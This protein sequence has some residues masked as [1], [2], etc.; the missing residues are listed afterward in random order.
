DIDL[1]K[2]LSDDSDANWRDSSGLRTI[3]LRQLDEQLYQTIAA[4]G[5]PDAELMNLGG[6]SRISLVH[7]DVVEQDIRLIGPAGQPSVGFRLEDLSLLASLV[8]DQTRPLGCSI[9]PQEAGLRRAHNMLANPQTVKLLARNP[10]RV[11]DQLADAVGPHEVSVFGMPASSPAALALVDADEHMKKVGF[12]KAQVRPAVRTYFQCLDDGAVPAQS[13]VRWWFAYRDASIGVN[14]AGDT[15]KLPNGC[16]AVMSEKQWMTAVG[17]KA[18]QN[19]DPAADKFAKEFTEKLPE[20]RKS[21]PAYARL[22]AIFETALALQLSVDAAGEPSLES[23]FPTL[24]GL[25][26]LSQADQPV[27]KSVDGLTTSHKLP[28]GTTIAVVSG[29][30]QITPSAAAELVKESKFMA[31][32]ALPREPEVKPAGQAKWWW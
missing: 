29:G 12:G 21:T 11:V 8:R 20:L 10:K 32:S 6:L 9:D 13:M 3:S 28:S 2:V 19:R 27:P 1:S 18:S 22:C 24:C 30:V 16:V 5:R 26:A 25:G 31:E 7:V 17:R 14:K 4:G 15:F 23:W